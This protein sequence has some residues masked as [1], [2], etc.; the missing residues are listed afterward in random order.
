MNTFSC[1]EKT[2]EKKKSGRNREFWKYHSVTLQPISTE[3]S[4]VK[5]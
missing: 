4:Q 1:S 2:A 5:I 3:K